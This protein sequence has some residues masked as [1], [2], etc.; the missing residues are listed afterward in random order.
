MNDEL[1]QLEAEG[2]AR[3]KEKAAARKTPEAKAKRNT[4]RAQR[5]RGYRA[6]KRIEAKLA[7]FGW[8]RVPLSGAAGGS[9]SGDLRRDRQDGRV[10]NVT[11]IKHRQNGWTTLRKWLAQGNA[12]WLVLD[13]GQGK[14]ALFVMQENKMLVLLEE[15]G[16]DA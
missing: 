5:N 7:R 16:Y 13:E 11:E 14:E 8:R 10:L 6:E 9:W 1:T 12:D 3:R 2:A 15:A 4:G